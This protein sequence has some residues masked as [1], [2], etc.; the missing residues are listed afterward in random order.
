MQEQ[1]V[2]YE[3]AV[4]L[5]ELGFIEPT[6][7]AYIG[8]QFFT[9]EVDL[10]GSDFS[11]YEH[12]VDVNEF[13]ENWNK[14][15][16]V[17]TKKGSECFGCKLDNVKYFEAFSAPP[18]NEVIDWLEKEYKIIIARDRHINNGFRYYVYSDKGFDI[19]CYKMDKIEAL[20]NAIEK[21]VEEALKMIDKK[22]FKKGG[23]LK[24][25]SKNKNMSKENE[26]VEIADYGDQMYFT[27]DFGHV[28]VGDDEKEIP[29]VLVATI[30]NFYEATGDDRFE[31]K[32]FIISLNIYPSIEFIDKAHI[33]SCA[34]SAGIEPE[35]VGYTDLVSYGLGIPLNL[36]NLEEGYAEMNDAEEFLKSK[37]LKDQLNAQSMLIGFYMDGA[38]NR[39]GDSRWAYLEHSL[40][41]SKSW[42]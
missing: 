23:D 25:N 21:A 37:E 17:F 4:K 10:S 7:N 41:K 26:F 39:A 18:Y 1:F 36:K 12:F 24:D 28:I 42:Y 2:T 16:W 14:P 30:E 31:E 29:L 6:I 20:N 5:K 35:E 32:P 33:E 15:K 38:I 13:Y 22:E 19:E 3:I 9:N 40:D 8:K 34:N 27:R 11:G